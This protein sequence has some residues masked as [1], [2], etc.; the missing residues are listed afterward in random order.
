[1]VPPVY[2]A[3]D[4]VPSFAIVNFVAPEALALKMSAELS[5]LIVAAAAPP[6]DPETCKAL[7]NRK[8]ALYVRLLLLVKYAI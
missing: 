8:L 3:S 1:M 2:F 4:M 7:L 6:F 5:W